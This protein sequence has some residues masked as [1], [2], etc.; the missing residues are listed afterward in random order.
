MKKMLMT[1]FGLIT[2]VSFAGEGKHLF[3][4]SGQSNMARF[5]P[6]V[7]FT[8]AVEKEF[9]KE[10]VIVVKNAQG[11]QPIRRWYKAWK[12]E[13]GVAPESTGDLYDRLMA[14]VK[15]A[16]DG[17]MIDTV[18]FIWMQGERDA[19][20]KHGG[21]YE[22]NLQG[23]VEQLSSD[24][25]RNDID[26]VIGRISDFGLK[27]RNPAEWIKVRD[28]QVHFAETYP[29]GAWIDT[30]DCN[31]GMNSQ[32]KDVVDDLHMSVDG[33]KLMGER[34]AEKAIRLIKNNQKK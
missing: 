25:K 7:S 6:N 9:G 2:A 16:I 26:V 24:L 30:D 29:R 19:R 28:A 14:E 1:V 32:G 5:D 10:N 23:L 13:K 17:Q 12:D 15:P 11:G 34:Y 8:P 27:S 33:Y 22:S 21:I 18:T 31:T 4:L 3:I 20:E